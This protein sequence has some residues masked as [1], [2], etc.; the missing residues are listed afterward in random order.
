MVMFEASTWEGTRRLALAVYSARL[1][2][3]LSDPKKF[4]RGMWLAFRQVTAPASPPTG[5]DCSY[6]HYQLHHTVLLPNHHHG[7]TSTDHR[8]RRKIEEQEEGRRRNV[9]V[10][11]RAGSAGD[12]PTQQ[13][14]PTYHR[15][16]CI[17]ACRF[18]LESANCKLD[19]N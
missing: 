18:Y 11:L 6:H 12:R 17:K 3:Q 8:S 15:F 2:L 10:V 14:L 1:C 9:T 13:Q 16:R 7:K 4:W 5:A 19:W